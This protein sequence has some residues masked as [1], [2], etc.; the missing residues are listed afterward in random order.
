MHLAEW[1][2]ANNL[3]CDDVAKGLGL[4]GERDA[5]SVWNWE[6]GRS[7]P[8]ADVVERII[9]FTK[10]EVSADDMH[11]VRLAWLKDNRPEKFSDVTEAAA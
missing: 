3:S 8:D 9:D 11:R 5:S 7:R 4:D 1:R 10:N 2:K 6:T